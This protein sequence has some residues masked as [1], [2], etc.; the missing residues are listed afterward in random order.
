MIA[1]RQPRMNRLA[2][3]YA[4]SWNTNMMPNVQVM[5]P[6]RD[7]VLAAAQEIGRDPATL[8]ITAGINVGFP[9]LPE[10]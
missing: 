4:D 2:A 1:S 7:A 9:D 10:E 6:G 3:Q 5:I 8:E